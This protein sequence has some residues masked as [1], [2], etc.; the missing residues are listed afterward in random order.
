M[1]PLNIALAGYQVV[2]GLS[3][4]Y[5]VTQ[6]YW[7]DRFTPSRFKSSQSLCEPHSYAIGDSFVTNQTI[8]NWNIASL[9]NTTNSATGYS[10]IPYAGVTLDGCDI[11]YIGV[12]ANLMTRTATFSAT[13]ACL[14]EGFPVY[15]STRFI[16]SPLMSTTTQRDTGFRGVMKGNSNPLVVTTVLNDAGSV[17]L[18][19]MEEMAIGLNNTGIPVMISAQSIL[20]PCP[21]SFMTTGLIPGCDVSSGYETP[22]LNISYVT[23]GL[24]NYYLL[25]GEDLTVPAEFYNSSVNNALQTFH[26][27]VRFDLGNALPNNLFTNTTAVISANQTILPTFP[28]EA[29]DTKGNTTVSYQESKLYDLLMGLFIADNATL[30]LDGSMR[31]TISVPFLCRFLELKRPG[32]AF[33][34]VL[35]ATLSMFSAGWAIFILIC[36]HF[37]K[38]GEPRANQ[39]E[40]HDAP[41]GLHYQHVQTSSLESPMTPGSA[42]KL[43]Y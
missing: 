28:L 40:A 9:W 16:A 26:A 41:S 6:S 31:S 12:D 39:C 4:D 13:I 34:A 24:P 27:A 10:G 19:D 5:G 7:Y 32:D 33:I 3:P 18:V 35:V 15:A 22:Q 37:A 36:G 21:R 42:R 23:M 38:R 1:V 25:Y 29:Y 2:S 20:T 11:D 8:F 43:A 14:G 30:P 17:L